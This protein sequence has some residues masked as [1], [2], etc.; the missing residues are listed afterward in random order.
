MARNGGNGHRYE[1]QGACAE[2]D[3]VTGYNNFD[4]R[5]SDGKIGRLLITI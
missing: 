3:P 2:K 5:M 4:L 1:Y